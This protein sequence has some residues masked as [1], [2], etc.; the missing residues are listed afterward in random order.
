MKADTSDRMAAYEAPRPEPP[1]RKMRDIL[2]HFRGHKARSEQHMTV[3]IPTGMALP[4]LIKY[5]GH[6]MV[7]RQDDSYAE[8]T[9]WP[10][11]EGL[12]G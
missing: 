5:R 11:V 12:D 1:I 9:V 7:R 10:I 6:L 4:D 3:Q 8:A 2:L